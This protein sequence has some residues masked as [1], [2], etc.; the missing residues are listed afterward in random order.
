MVLQERAEKT[1]TGGSW[2][3]RVQVF[4]LLTWTRE[5]ECVFCLNADSKKMHSVNL[6]NPGVILEVKP[7]DGLHSRRFDL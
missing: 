1:N 2:K 3:L 5:R 7:S 6:A 4:V